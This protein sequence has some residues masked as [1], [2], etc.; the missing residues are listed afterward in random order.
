MHQAFVVS[1]IP[2]S[3]VDLELVMAWRSHPEAY[4]YFREQQRPLTWQEHWTFW[5]NRRNREDYIINVQEKNKKRKVGNINLSQLNTPQPEIGIIIGELTLYGKGVASQA[6]KLGLHRLVD[7]GHVQ[8]RVT[9]NRN[10]PASQ[11]VFKKFGFKKDPEQKD[12][13]WEHYTLEKIDL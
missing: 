11:A 3:E 1:L 7:L 10:N 5:Q 12:I 8:A 2:M 4:R 9:I 6:V 13:E